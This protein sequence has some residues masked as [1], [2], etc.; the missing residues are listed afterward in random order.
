MHGGRR[1]RIGEKCTFTV[2]KDM[3]GGKIKAEHK[4]VGKCAGDLLVSYRNCIIQ[5][6]SIKKVEKSPIKK[7]KAPTA[8]DYK[9]LGDV[10][11]ETAIRYRDNFT[12]V[13][14]GEKFPEFT[15]NELQ[16]GHGVSR[17]HWAT[18]HNP[19]NCHAITSGQNFH[20]SLGT[21]KTIAQ[22]WAYVAKKYGQDVVDSLL[23]EKHESPKLSIGYLKEDCEKQYNFLTECLE[24]WNKTSKI[25][26][27]AFEVLCIRCEK[28]PKAKKEGIFK[29]LTEIKGYW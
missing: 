10:L 28:F 18:R 1:M 19:L 3:F 27:S 14:S 21:A 7:E 25:K 6:K 15:W 8:S 4:Y 16:A 11:F 23:N 12:S 26:R 13:I 5:V 29:A 17:Q 22:Y 20:M 9:N 2:G 24:K